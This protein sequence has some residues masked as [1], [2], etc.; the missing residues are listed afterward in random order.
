MANPTILPVATILQCAKLGLSYSVQDAK[1]KAAFQ[2]G[3]LNMSLPR[4]IFMVLNSVEHRFNSYPTDPTLRATSNFLWDLLGIYG[5]RALKNLQGG[6]SV[7]INPGGGLVLIPFSE[8]FVV[9]TSYPSGATSV[10][11]NWRSFGTSSDNIQVILQNAIV[12]PLITATAGDFTYD[13]TF[14]ASI[15]TIRFQANGVATAPDDGQI[16]IINGFKYQ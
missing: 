10:T 16:L 14:N 2:G 5:L 9:G 12:N 11:L 4:T 13:V 7:I 3:V 1:Q 6:G 15:T 8:T